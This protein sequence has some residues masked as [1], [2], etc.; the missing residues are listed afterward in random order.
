MGLRIYIMKLWKRPTRFN[1]ALQ[2]RIVCVIQRS[3]L[4]PQLKTIINVST[5]KHPTATWTRRSLMTLLAQI[6]SN[7]IARESSLRKMM[8]MVPLMWYA[9]ELL[10]RTA[11][12]F[13]ER[14]RLKCVRLMSID[15]AK[16]SLTRTHSLLRSKIATL[17]QSRSELEM[18]TRPKKAKKYSYTKDCKEQPR[19]I[20]DQCETQSLEPACDF[21]ERLTCSYV[22]KEQCSE[23]AKQYCHKVE[24]INLV[25]VC[26][27]KFDNR[28]L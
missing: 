7:S 5:S 12:T 25:E 8:D 27:P 24:K 13:Q 28:Y 2:G 18:K 17:N 14:S 20:C 21:Q 19:A 3:K 26:N 6:L 16:S 23:E 11:I 22:P 9:C 1:D 10:N 4:I 15:I